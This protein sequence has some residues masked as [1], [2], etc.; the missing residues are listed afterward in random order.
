MSCLKNPRHVVGKS[1]E[2][3][4]EL[5]AL[6][7]ELKTIK[8]ELGGLDSRKKEIENAPENGYR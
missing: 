6:C 3:D 5:I 1:V 7:S 8:E 2:A 4:D